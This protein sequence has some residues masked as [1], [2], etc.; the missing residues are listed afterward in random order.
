MTMEIYDIVFAKRG[1]TLPPKRKVTYY[2]DIEVEIP[3][4]VVYVEN[5]E[6]GMKNLARG[7]DACL[8]WENE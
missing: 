3:Y 2:P 8:E 1:E 5:L 4:K 6:E 7:V